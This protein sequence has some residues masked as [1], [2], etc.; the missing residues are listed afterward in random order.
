MA[1]LIVKFKD[2]EKHRHDILS[3]D[4]RIGRD[5]TNDVVIDNP[6]ISRHHAT[7]RWDG[8]QWLVTDEG[9]QNG[10]F[11]NGQKSARWTLRDGDAIQVGKFE[12]VFSIRGGRAT[13]ELE[14]RNDPAL[15]K[16]RNPLPTVALSAEDMQRYMAEAAAKSGKP[17]GA[18]EVRRPQTRVEVEDDEAEGTA[19]GY[20]N[21]AIGLGV[22]V[23]ALTGLTVWLLVGRS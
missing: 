15:A 14:D 7:V 6:G 22:L 19:A 16:L 2:R 8:K 1:Q 21:L 3:A 9:S 23:L 18:T 10:L 13:S 17:T 4:T 20:R 11:I 5:E 12:V